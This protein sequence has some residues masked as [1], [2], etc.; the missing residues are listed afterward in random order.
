MLGCNEGWEAKRAKGT[1]THLSNTSIDSPTF[2]NESARP[3]IF[4]DDTEATVMPMRRGPERWRLLVC[5]PLSEKKHHSTRSPC[6]RERSG[7]KV[8]KYGVGSAAL[9]DKN[10][11]ASANVPGG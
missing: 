9:G 8:S 3:M 4:G 1:A 7:V 6:K 10:A 11:Y 5:V 2:A